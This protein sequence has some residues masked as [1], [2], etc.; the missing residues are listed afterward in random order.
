MTGSSCSA[1]T[2][3]DAGRLDDL[4][5]DGAELLRIAESL[6]RCADQNQTAPGCSRGSARRGKEN[7]H[8]Q[9]AAGTVPD[10]LDTKQDTFFLF[11]GGTLPR[12]AQ[13][14]RAFSE[15]RDL[16]NPPRCAIMCLGTHNMKER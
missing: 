7:G 16:T 9:A 11:A 13:L 12:P 8:F 1:G 15:K 14:D 4:T 3:T 2:D 10:T 6:T 5:G